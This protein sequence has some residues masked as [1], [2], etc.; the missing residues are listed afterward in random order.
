MRVK[1]NGIHVA[2]ASAAGAPKNPV[3]VRQP[4]RPPRRPHPGWQQRHLSS[5][6]RG[7]RQRETA[8]VDDRRAILAA[9]PGIPTTCGGPGDS[10]AP[11]R[12]D[13]TVRAAVP[14]AAL[15]AYWSITTPS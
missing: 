1:D 12:A 9:L 3:L 6:A 7:V 5:G 2:V 14:R 8:L 15:C 11:A 13:R 4:H 10:A